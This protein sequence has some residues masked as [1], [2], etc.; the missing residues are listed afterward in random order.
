MSNHLNAF[1]Q[2]ISEELNV[3]EVQF[4]DDIKELCDMKFKPNFKSLAKKFGKNVKT[5]ANVILNDHENVEKLICNC[6]D[7][8]DV[9]GQKITSEDVIVDYVPKSGTDDY[10]VCVKDGIAVALNIKLTP[11]LLEEGLANEFIAAVQNL[12]KKFSFHITQHICVCVEADKDVENAIN[13]HIDKVCDELR[14]DN[15]VFNFLPECKNIVN[16]NGHDTKIEL[17]AS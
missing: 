15:I 9:N 8:I 1:K 12:R 16:L 4:V 6:I 13:K 17:S 10:A 5:A 11:E 2:L 7:S 3:K 14:I